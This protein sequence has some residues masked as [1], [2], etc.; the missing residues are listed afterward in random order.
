M[1]PRPFGFPAWINCKRR[2]AKKRLN[3]YGRN[4]LKRYEHFHDAPYRDT[5]ISSCS[6]LNEVIT[7][8][9][10]IY[11]SI[12]KKARVLVD[13]IFEGPTNSCSFYN[14]GVGPAKTY[15][16]C[17]TYIKFIIKQ[18]A[19]HDEWGF[20]ERYGRCQLNP[21]GTYKFISKEKS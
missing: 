20:V 12:G 21:D 3:R 18:W 17:Q 13:I 15:E 11:R 10:P 7:R 16:E 14:C 1:T 9:F 5:L 4:L 6:G 8:V 19:G 2:V